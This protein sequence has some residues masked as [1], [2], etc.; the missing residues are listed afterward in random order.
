MTKGNFNPFCPRM[1]GLIRFLICTR[2]AG[3]P[4]VT[5]AT[6]WKKAPTQSR[7]HCWWY[8]WGLL[9]VTGVA[10]YGWHRPSD[11]LTISHVRAH[12]HPTARP[13]IP[14]LQQIA[15]YVCDFNSPSEEALNTA[16]Y[17]LLDTLGCGFLALKYP[18]RTKL[19]GPV[20]PGT[21]VRTVRVFPGR[22]TFSIR[23]P[24]RSTSA[25]SCA[26]WISTTPGSRRNGGIRPTTSARSSPSPTFNQQSGNRQSAILHRARHPARD[27]QGA[28]NPGHPRAWKIVSTRRPR[29]RLA[30][31]ASSTAVA[32]HLL[33]GTR[34]QI[35]NAV[36]N[37]GLMAAR[38]AL[39]ATRPTPARA[40]PG[41]P[42]TPP[43]APC[44]TRSWR[45]KARWVILRTLRAQ[46]GFQRRAVQEPVHQTRAP[47]RFAT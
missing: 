24:P 45:S 4:A 42:A 6:F 44:N 14:L 37:A 40:N 46:V 25:H 26:G 5:S 38:S 21:V 18:A 33:G 2:S 28:R 22:T 32:T 7:Q 41:P 13:S 27:D 9:P 35:M 31:S 17:C 36:S 20:V 23:S 12:Q 19:L 39:I 34:E 8:R 10:L 43:R 3:L 29:S 16:R 30:R 47:V 15:D 11:N 1:F